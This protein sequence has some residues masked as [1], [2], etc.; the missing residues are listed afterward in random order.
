MW[1]DKYLKNTYG[2]VKM[3]METKDDDKQNLP[4]DRLFKDFLNVYNESNL[5]MVD[6]V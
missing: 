1:T 2:E 5:Y 3:H 4:P 6:E